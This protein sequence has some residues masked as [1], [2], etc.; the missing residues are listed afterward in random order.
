[1]ERMKYLWEKLSGFDVLFNDF[2]RGDY[3]AFVNHFIVQID[4]QPTPAGL[5]WD[6]DDVGIILINDIVPFQ[7]AIAHFVFWDRRFRGRENLCR[8]M[9]KYGFKTYKFRR[10]RVEVPLYAKHTMEAVE[11]IG[12]VREGRMR[13]AVLW[14]KEWFDVYMYSILPE[15]LEEER[16]KTTTG[17]HFQTC[18]ECGEAYSAKQKAHLMSKGWKEGGVINDRA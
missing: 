7:S 15:D 11:R 14:K 9:L 10:I 4:G 8:E 16:R 2:V 13:K 6:V 18:F 17:P 3:K 5:F 12:F 1:M